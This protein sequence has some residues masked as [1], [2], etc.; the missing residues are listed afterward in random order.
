LISALVVLAA[1]GP[2]CQ[3]FLRRQVA[4]RIP[5]P[6]PASTGQYEVGAYY[7]PG[8]ATQ[9][10]WKVLDAFPERRPLLGY[11]AEGDP[12]VMDWQIKWAVEHGISF[13]AFD[14]YWDRGR[15]Q[16]EHALHQGYLRAPFRTYLKFCVLWANHNPPGSSSEADL[17][18][19]VDYWIESYFRRP[20]Y[21]TLDSRPVVIIFSPK[22]LRTDLGTGGVAAAFHAMRARV[23]GAGFPDIYLM[24][25]V[26]DN[27]DDIAALSTEGYDAGTGYNYPWAGL[28]DASARRG[29]YDDAVDGYERIWTRIAAFGILPYAPVTEPGWDARPWYGDRA[30]VRTGR[31]PRKFRDMLI[32]ARTFV[33]R[34]PLPGGKKIV[35]VEAWNEYG[36]GEVIEPH[37][38][39]GFAYLDAIREVFAD[40]RRPHRDLTPEDLGL[41]V[42]VAP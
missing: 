18:A 24:G 38:E 5:A 22:R 36:E 2:G 9:E 33:D 26:D 39:W 1:L 3:P 7:F 12:L 11:Y 6:R 31:S 32:R 15:R 23:R 8:W 16:L 40:D 29:S 19:M 21:L 14:W 37:R 10:K 34:H 27:P 20:E 35:L 4:L 25:A 30:L 42:P 13:F 17:L 41:G 28:K